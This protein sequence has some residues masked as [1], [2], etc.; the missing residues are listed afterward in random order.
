MVTQLDAKQLAIDFLAEDLGL[1]DEEKEWLTVLDSR[2]IDDGWY[3]VEVG[4]EGLPDKWVVQVYENG[5]CDPCYTFISPVLAA[6]ITTDL[7][8]LPEGIVMAIESER[9]GQIVPIGR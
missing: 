9:A 5:E 4:V 2:L 3:I 6:E 1:L 8:D 7:E